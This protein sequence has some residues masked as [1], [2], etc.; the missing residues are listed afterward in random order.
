MQP[1]PAADLRINLGTWAVPTRQMPAVAH[2][3]LDALPNEEFDPHFLGQH[4]ETTYFDTARFAL[5]KARRLGA[6]YITVRVRCYQNA[7]GESYALS[8][9]TESTKFRVEIGADDADMLISGRDPLPRLA[10]LLD[11]DLLARLLLVADGQALQPVVAVRAQRY[12][13]EDERW[14]F[15]LDT[16][17]STDLGRTLPYGVL[18]FKS[19]E[20]DTPPQALQAIKLRPMKLSKFLWATER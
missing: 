19:T 3:M 5:R 13:I 14:R 2:F 7:D 12:A 15:T 18:E 16:D 20:E 17:I 9:K 10:D 1:L 6:H 8:A 11:P 4:L